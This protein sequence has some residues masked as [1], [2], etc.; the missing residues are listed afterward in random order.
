MILIRSL[1]ILENLF[2]LIQTFKSGYQQ[3][4]NVIEFLLYN[5]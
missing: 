1:I 4:L 5:L 3:P 2:G